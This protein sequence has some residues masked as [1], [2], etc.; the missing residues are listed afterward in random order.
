[1]FVCVISDYK[2]GT[3]QSKQLAKKTKMKSILITLPLHMG[4]ELFKTQQK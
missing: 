2:L 1:M 3:K 4:K